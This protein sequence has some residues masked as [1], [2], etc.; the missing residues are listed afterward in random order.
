M[1]VNN[2][3]TGNEKKHIKCR[4][5]CVFCEKVAIIE[6]KTWLN[7]GLGKIDLICIPTTKERKIKEYLAVCEKVCNFAAVF[8]R[9]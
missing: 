1:F 3:T 7:V 5:K 6:L 4:F 8:K 2:H 9:I